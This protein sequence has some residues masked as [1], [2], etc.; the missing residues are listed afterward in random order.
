MRRCGWRTGEPSVDHE[1]RGSDLE[2]VW[3]L[4]QTQASAY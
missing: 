1:V 3:D 2:V 4:T